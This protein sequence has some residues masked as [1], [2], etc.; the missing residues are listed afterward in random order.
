MVQIDP[1]SLTLFSVYKELKR[2]NELCIATKSKNLRISST[3]G[4]QN[5]FNS[6]HLLFGIFYRPTIKYIAKFNECKKKREKMHSLFG[7]WSLNRYVFILA[8]FI[9]HTAYVAVCGIHFICVEKKNPRTNN[10]INLQDENT[11]TDNNT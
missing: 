8:R 9:L 7:S 5:T 3:S 6:K 4:K 11:Q 1:Y 10:R 2:P